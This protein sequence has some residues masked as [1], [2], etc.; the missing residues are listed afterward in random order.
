MK[1]RVLVPVR[2]AEVGWVG[3]IVGVWGVT[4]GFRRQSA[5]VGGG[6]VVWCWI[7]LGV[8]EG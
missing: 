6:V 7:F 1:R 8:G 4:W 2:R 3:G 5:K